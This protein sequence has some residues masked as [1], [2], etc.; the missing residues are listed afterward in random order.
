MRSSSARATS[1][2]SFARGRPPFCLEPWVRWSSGR[3]GR[4]SW[5]R[6]GCGFFRTCAGAT[7][8]PSAH[9][10][11]AVEADHVPVQ[12]LVLDDVAGE[13]GVFV[14]TSEARREGDL[15]AERGADLLAHALEHRGVE[16][17]RR[18]GHHPNAE[19]RELPG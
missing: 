2:E 4:S 9:A 5:W 10:D 16:D 3:S 18:D 12:D 19:F 11:G 14:G 8:L 7:A 6:R 13:G 15:L 17:A 1:S